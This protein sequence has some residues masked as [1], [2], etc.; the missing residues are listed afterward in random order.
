MSVNVNYFKNFVE[1]C[2]NKVQVGGTVSPAQFDFLANQAQLLIFE[3]DRQIFLQTQE[4]SD[5]LELFFKNLTTS[6]PPT[7]L[8]A[9]PSDFQHTASVRAYYVRAAGQST[10]ITVDPVKNKDWGDISS[11]QLQKPTKRFPKYTEFKR[12]YRFLPMDIGTVMVDYFATPRIP[13][14]GFT[15]ISGRPVY[16]P[17]TSVDF[18]FDEFAINAVA[19]AY[20][21]F[22][23]VN[24]KDGELSQFAQMFKQESNS[25]L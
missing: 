3:K 4:T 21:Q 9:Y 22:I 6:V 24:L 7:G 16:N 10:E 23:G 18:E 2:A 12:E 14:W 11:S 8:L 1:F 15:M 20:L 13:V 19:S 5:Y 25:P 17:A